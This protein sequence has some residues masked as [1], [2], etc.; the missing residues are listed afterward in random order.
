MLLVTSI[1]ALHICDLNYI[2]WFTIPYM[3]GQ[4]YY[5]GNNLLCLRTLLQAALQYFGGLLSF[6]ASPGKYCSV[7]LEYAASAWYSRALRHSKDPSACDLNMSQ[8]L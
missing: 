8:Q 6:W 1:A 4:S 5:Q 3:T 2:D 7:A